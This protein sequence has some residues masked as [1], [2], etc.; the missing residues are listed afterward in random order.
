MIKKAFSCV[1]LAIECAVLTIWYARYAVLL[2]ITAAWIVLFFT[3]GVYRTR[4]MACI[5]ALLLIPLGY[6]WLIRRDDKYDKR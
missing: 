2:L 4:G 5:G 1:M 6:Y 3:G